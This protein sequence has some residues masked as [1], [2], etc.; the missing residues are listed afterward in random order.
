MA[1]NKSAPRKYPYSAFVLT[2]AYI[3]R[4]VTFVRKNQWNYRDM[5]ISAE[6]KS[7]AVEKIHTTKAD[8]IAYG[9]Q[10]IVLREEYLEKQHALLD[11]RRIKMDKAEKGA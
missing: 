11:A 9:R 8:A 1:T 7:F 10:Q 2:P 5:D 6:G 3:V 4:P